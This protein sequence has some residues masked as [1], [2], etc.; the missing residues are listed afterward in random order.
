MDHE[1]EIK[2]YNTI[3]TINTIQYNTICN[4]CFYRYYLESIFVKL[5]FI[6]E[7]SADLGNTY[8]RNLAVVIHLTTQLF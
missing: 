1:S 7:T 3:N 4:N 8:P 6:L 5:D 2:I